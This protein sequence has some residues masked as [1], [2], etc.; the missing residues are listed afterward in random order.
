MV[1]ITIYFVFD[2]LLLVFNCVSFADINSSNRDNGSVINIIFFSNA[3]TGRTLDM[4]YKRDTITQKSSENEIPFYLV[5]E[6]RCKGV[7]NVDTNYKD[8]V[9]Y[10]D[11]ILVSCLFGTYF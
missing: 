3:M 4:R 9:F 11:F 5:T 8:I 6:K 2:M 7:E 1:S 10:F